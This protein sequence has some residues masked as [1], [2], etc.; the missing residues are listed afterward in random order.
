MKYPLLQLF[1]ANWKLPLALIFIKMRERSAFIQHAATTRI[2]H[3]YYTNPNYLWIRSYTKQTKEKLET[4]RFSAH[5]GF[6]FFTFNI[7]RI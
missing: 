1:G 7:V 3:T 5:F 6:Y 4:S 2:R